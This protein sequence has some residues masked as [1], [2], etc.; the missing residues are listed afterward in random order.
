[1]AETQQ[2]YEARF[3][4]YIVGRDWMKMQRDAPGRIAAI[5]EGIAEEWLQRKPAPGKWSVGEILAHLAEDELSSSWRYRQMIEHDG[6]AL[7]SFDQDLWAR[8]ADYAAWNPRDALT[9][10][11]LLREANVRLLDGLSQEQWECSGIHVERGRITVR[12]LARH[13]AAHDVNHIE[14]IKRLLA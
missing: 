3:E 9:L 11:G 4:S 7:Q 14:Q 12:Q 5:V 8:L 13:M 2:E 10:Y 1:M 6:D